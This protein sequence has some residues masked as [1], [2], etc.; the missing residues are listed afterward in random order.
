MIRILLIMTNSM[1]YTGVSAVVMNYYTFMD[2]S[3][4]QID[5]VIP[6][7]VEERFINQIEGN[8]GKLYELFMKE[9]NVILYFAKLLKIIRA[10]NYDIVHAHGN[11]ST[12]FLEMAAAKIAG[13]KVRIAHSHN[14]TC[15]HKIVN[16]ILRPFFLRS[17]THGFACSKKAGRWLFKDRSFTV[18]PNGIDTEKYSFNDQTREEYR[19]R[20]HLQD[21]KVIGHVGAMNDQKNHDF[22]IDIFYELSKMDPKYILVLIGDGDLRQE[23]T[24]KVTVLAIEDKVL[25][26]GKSLEVPKLLQAMDIMLLPSRYEGLPVVMLEWQCAGLPMIVSDKV[27]KEAKLTELVEFM[28]IETDAREWAKRINEIRILDRNDSKDLLISKIRHAGYDIRD[29][30]V[31][32]KRIYENLA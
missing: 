22:L 4:M 1:G 13:V 30:A 27:T 6:N 32:L 24:R 2:K 19:K 16:K 31:K 7:K 14:S 23:I 5:F 29:S 20:Y 12:L 21:K 18:I 25:F 17:Y 11:S 28:P 9:K 10:G 15:A 26:L 3:G 8:G